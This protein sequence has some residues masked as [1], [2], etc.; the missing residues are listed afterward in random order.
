MTKLSKDEIR[1]NLEL[2]EQRCEQHGIPKPTTFVYPG[3]HHS[4]P[5]VEVLAE[6]QY[7]FA[8]RSVSPEHPDDGSGVRGRSYDPN[9]DHPLLIPTSGYAGPEWSFEDLVWRSIKPETGRSRCLPFTACPRSST[10]GSTPSRS[11]S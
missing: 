8:R 10:P 9:E 4:L 5:V 1:A 11:T 2:I 3:W 7:V 6:K